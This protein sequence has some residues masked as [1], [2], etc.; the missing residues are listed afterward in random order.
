MA[1]AALVLTGCSAGT[2]KIRFGAAGLGGTYRVVA[3]TFSDLVMTKNED[4][5]LEVK[6]TAGSAANIRL[7]SD[8][9]I[10]M[11]IAQADLV[12]DAYYGTGLYEG[13][14]KEQGYSAIGSIYVEKCQIVVRADSEIHTVE[15]LQG[16]TVSVGE[17]E[18][19]TEQNAD[20]I[21]AAYGLSDR[22]VDEVNLDYTQAAEELESGKIDAFFCTAG[23]QTTVIGEL[24]KQCE[25]RL[26]SLDDTGIDKLT[27][28]Y[29]FYTECEIPSGTYTGQNEAVKTVG[30]NAVLLASDKLSEKTVEE[31]TQ[32]L[33]ENKQELQYSLPVDILPDEKTAVQ[34]VTIPFHEGA[35]AYYQSCGIDVSVENTEDS[36]N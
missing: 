28:S 8:G 21:L 35:A 20:Q 26:I 17:E 5:K 6:T 22:L 16:K 1:S 11:A 30:V 36:G 23:T 9:Y 19:G 31:L 2:G 7:L 14:D 34:G 33:F 32:I 15:D 24:A 3:D 10:Q 29:D 25:I 12:N 18:S 27:K 13:H 4:Y